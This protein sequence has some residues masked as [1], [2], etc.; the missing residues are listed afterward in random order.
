MD[1]LAELLVTTFSSPWMIPALIGIAVVS[2]LL[3]RFLEYV[4]WGLQARDEEMKEMKAKLS[5]Y[6]V[7]ENSK[8]GF[9]RVK[10][11]EL[12]STL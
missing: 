1:Y 9:T 7:K 10:V 8:V 12:N 2:T 11:E 5:K 6:E 4:S 3:N